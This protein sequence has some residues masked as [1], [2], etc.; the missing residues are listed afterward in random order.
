VPVILE[1]N[2]IT[3]AV[4]NRLS[5]QRLCPVCRNEITYHNKRAFNR[6]EKLQHICRGCVATTANYVW[7][8]KCKTFKK[9]LIGDR[10]GKLVVLNKQ[11]RRGNNTIWLCQCDCGNTKIVSRN[12]LTNG[13]S[14][15]SC[16]CAILQ[17][18]HNAAWKGYGEISG[19]YWKVIRAG[20]RS[21]KL[22]FEI[23]IESAWEK[24][25]SQGRKCAF[26]GIGLNFVNHY[27]K[28]CVQQTASLDRIDSSKGYVSG[29]IQWVH[30]R[31]NIMKMQLL[32]DDFIFWCSAVS[33][34][35]RADNA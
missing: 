19:S 2:V 9:D 4:T 11:G 26:T 14:I 29:N 25:L 33:D 8:N 1:S 24:F 5:F 16:G 32:P 15:K 28:D 35:D 31:I 23:T 18:L 3:E 34:K 22:S 17:N 21:R 10:F 6:A 30:K 13:K 27:C 20:A 7:R 12:Y